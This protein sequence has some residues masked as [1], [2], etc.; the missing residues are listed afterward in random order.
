M[1]KI[2]AKNEKE[3]LYTTRDCNA[4]TTKLCR[5]HIVVNEQ[6]A[7][8]SLA[9]SS[10]RPSVRLYMLRIREQIFDVPLRQCPACEHFTKCVSL[11][12]VDSLVNSGKVTV[13]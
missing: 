3:D 10:L 13:R 2:F 7:S 8:S 4:S 6:F 11:D 12:S 1:I 5:V 9:V